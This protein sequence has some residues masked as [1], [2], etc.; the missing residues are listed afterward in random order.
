MP[1]LLSKERY[2]PGELIVYGWADYEY[3]KCGTL[4][5]SILIRIGTY[6]GSE[7][8]P[9]TGLLRHI[10]AAEA[11]M[12]CKASSYAGHR[13]YVPM[14]VLSHVTSENILGTVCGTLDCSDPYEMKA[15]LKQV[16]KRYRARFRDD[17]IGLALWLTK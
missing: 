9:D 15:Y 5:P 7:I 10:I 4:D 1:L 2:R 14:G 17:V 13:F 16:F 3:S 8:N 11:N 12:Y 6:K